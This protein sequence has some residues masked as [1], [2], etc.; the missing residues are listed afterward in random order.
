MMEIQ[1][2]SINSMNGYSDILR[3]VRMTCTRSLWVYVSHSFYKNS[4]T[5]HYVHSMT[6]SFYSSLHV[7]FE[8]F[9]LASSP[10]SSSAS[11][12]VSLS[13]WICHKYSTSWFH[14]ENAF[15][16]SVLSQSS[17]AKI[18]KHAYEWDLHFFLP[19]VEIAPHFLLF[20]TLM[21]IIIF[22]IDKIMAGIFFMQHPQTT[23]VIPFYFH[24]GIISKQAVDFA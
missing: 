24:I 3:S 15:S 2:T 8:I 17:T 11:E 9:I 13:L 6:A 12:F 5:L 7:V 1:M 18:E 14:L 19:F 22:N 20:L 16:C 23:R 10:F 4:S 21:D